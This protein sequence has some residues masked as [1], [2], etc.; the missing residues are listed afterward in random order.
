MEREE[1]ERRLQYKSGLFS[2]PLFEDR[3][4]QYCNDD[5]AF[6]P[7]M[8][9]FLSCLESLPEY[10]VI[11]YKLHLDSPAPNIVGTTLLGMIS[12]LLGNSSRL[13]AQRITNPFLVF[14]KTHAVENA[15]ST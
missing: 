4:S 6:I 13:Y 12:C 15:L 8:A 11:G 2:G 5:I 7:F 1:L 9:L 14:N 3:C 10:G